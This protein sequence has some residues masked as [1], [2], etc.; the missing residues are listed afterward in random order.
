MAMPEEDLLGIILI[1]QPG[2]L[3]LTC[4]RNFTI[5]KI[6]KNENTQFAPA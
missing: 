5:I 1:E 2:E 3:L 6:Q 4:Q